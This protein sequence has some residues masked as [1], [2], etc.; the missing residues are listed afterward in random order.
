MTR[1]NSG[2]QTHKEKRWIV[3]EAQKFQLTS[4]SGSKPAKAHEAVPRAGPRGSAESRPAAR[5]EAER[6]EPGIRNPPR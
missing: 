3:T 5:L 2:P 1:N 6:A 4:R